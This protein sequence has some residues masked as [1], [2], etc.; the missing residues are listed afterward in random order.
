MVRNFKHIRKK[1]VLN[2]FRGVAGQMPPAPN[3][4]T[5]RYDRKLDT[6]VSGKDL[7]PQGADPPPPYSFRRRE[8]M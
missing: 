7:Q 1:Q 3:V 6:A 4:A 2:C 5:Q 8:G